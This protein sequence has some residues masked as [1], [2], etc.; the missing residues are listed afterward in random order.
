MG[1]QAKS[2]D[3]PKTEASPGVLSPT[4]NLGVQQRELKEGQERVSN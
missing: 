2:N 4:P 1:G 3:M